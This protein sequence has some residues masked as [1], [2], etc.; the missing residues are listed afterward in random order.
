MF[1]YLPFILLIRVITLTYLLRYLI[2]IHMY[3]KYYT[4]VHILIQLI[5]RD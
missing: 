4:Y 3:I 5:D 1:T 2:H